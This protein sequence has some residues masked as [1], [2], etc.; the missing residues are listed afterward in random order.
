MISFFKKTIFGLSKTRSKLSNLFAG[1]AG[2]SI[3]DELDLETLEEALLTADIGW[4]L[5]K[6]ILEPSTSKHFL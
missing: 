5:T 1:F 4:E 2:R 3:L 6:I